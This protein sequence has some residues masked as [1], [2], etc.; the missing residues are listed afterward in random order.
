MDEFKP[1]IENGFLYSEVVDDDHYP[2]PRLQRQ[3]FLNL[4]G[5]P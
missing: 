4:E 3:I 2:P 1:P 5:Q